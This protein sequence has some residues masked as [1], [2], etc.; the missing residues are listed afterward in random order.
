MN[1]AVQRHQHLILQFRVRYAV[2][3]SPVSTIFVL[4]NQLGEDDGGARPNLPVVFRGGE[5][6]GFAEG[7]GEDAGNEDVELRWNERKK[8]KRS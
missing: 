4:A 2:S 7:A 5:A 8:R 3:S 1:H 6:E